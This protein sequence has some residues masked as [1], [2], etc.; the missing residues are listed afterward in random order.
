MG[1]GVAIDDGF[2]YRVRQSDL[3]FLQISSD[4]INS[5]HSRICPLG[6]SASQFSYFLET[7]EQ[8]LARDA[9]ASVDVRLQGS[10]AH[11][12]SGHHKE[13]P[14][15]REDLVEEF[16]KNRRRVPAG[17]EIDEAEATMLRQWPE[18]T[19]PKRRP[20]DAMFRLGLDRPSDVDLQIASD[21]IVDRARQRITALGIRPERLTVHSEHYAFVR[22]DLVEATCPSLH[23]WSMHTSDVL[24]R[25][26]TVAVFSSGGPPRTASLLSSHFRDDDWIL[27]QK[28][29]AR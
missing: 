23:L 8:A 21:E 10:A 26:V 20:F 12:F 24:R 25:N 28:W 1:P 19:R 18:P 11:F 29:S 22:K 14:W 5:W 7:L 15:R 4:A 17:F 9:I 3:D 6:M 2:G 27:L 13:M 16:R